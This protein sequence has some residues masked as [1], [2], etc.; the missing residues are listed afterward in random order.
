MKPT[1]CEGKDGSL[2]DEEQ[3]GSATEVES[4]ITCLLPEQKVDDLPHTLETSSKLGDDFKS[5]SP[6]FV[7]ID[8]IDFSKIRQNLDAISLQ[9]N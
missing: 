9:T 3:V 5:I 2:L 7:N 1:L 6:T 8:K 4:F